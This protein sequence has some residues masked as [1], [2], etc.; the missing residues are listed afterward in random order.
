MSITRTN[1]AKKLK[2][3]KLRQSTHARSSTVKARDAKDAQKVFRYF[4]W[5]TI[6]DTEHGRNLLRKGVENSADYLSVHAAFDETGHS[7]FEKWVADYFLGL[8]SATERSAAFLEM[9]TPEAHP[10][11]VLF[12]STPELEEQYF[13]LISAGALVEDGLSDG[14]FIASIKVPN[15]PMKA[16]ISAHKMST[17]LE[18]FG[19]EVQSRLSNKNFLVWSKDNPIWH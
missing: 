16:Q 2:A 11:F 10:L 19:K 13:Q 15:D 3:A 6:Q 5:D 9:V 7:S 14:R 17:Q 4:E 1:N 12:S 18:A 8:Y